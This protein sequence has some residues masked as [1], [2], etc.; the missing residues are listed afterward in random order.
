[1]LGQTQG[2]HSQTKELMQEGKKW[3]QKPK[4]NWTKIMLKDLINPLG[5][6]LYVTV[7]LIHSLKSSWRPHLQVLRDTVVAVSL[8]E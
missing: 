3:Q 1:M 4:T 8:W 7:M 5:L 6:T 2:G